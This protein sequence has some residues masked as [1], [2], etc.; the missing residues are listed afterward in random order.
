MVSSSVVKVVVLE[1]VVLVVVG[2]VEVVDVRR[3]VDSVV[4]KL[5]AGVVI[6]E[7]NIPST[8]ETEVNPDVF[9]NPCIV[10]WSAFS[11][12]SSKVSNKSAFLSKTFTFRAISEAPSRFAVAHL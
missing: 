6:T 1:T 2:Y 7:T 12:S 9:D 4:F 8:F 5:C 3:N 10:V 11:C